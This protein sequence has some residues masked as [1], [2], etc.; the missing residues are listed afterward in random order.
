MF[1]NFQINGFYV[2]HH[3]N[4]PDSAFIIN[5]PPQPPPESGIIERPPTTRSSPPSRATADKGFELQ[6]DKFQSA[7]LTVE[8]S[9]F[10]I[11]GNEYH[12]KDFRLRVGTVTL[13]SSVKVYSK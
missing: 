3:S 7:G 2:I 1:K 6:L 9:K 13:G 12:L 11:V 5:A 4:F 8:P 10:E